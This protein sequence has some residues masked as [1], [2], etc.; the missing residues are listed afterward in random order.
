[1]IILFLEV[2]VRKQNKLNICSK[3]WIGFFRM[4]TV[5]I[6]LERIMENCSTNT[7]AQLS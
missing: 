1:M 2:Q 4:V 7:K 5:S 3:A 6:Y